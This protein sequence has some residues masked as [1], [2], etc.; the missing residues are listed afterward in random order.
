MMKRC[1]RDFLKANKKKKRERDRGKKKKPMDDLMDCTNLKANMVL[2]HAVCVG[3][4]VPARC[5]GQRFLLGHT[6]ARGASQVLGVGLC[7][8]RDA[9]AALWS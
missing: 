3:S 5:L 6:S 1:K 2:I 7:L 8:S 4:G 9:L